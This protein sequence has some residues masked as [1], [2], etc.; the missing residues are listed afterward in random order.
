LFTPPPGVTV[1]FDSRWPDGSDDLPLNEPPLARAPGA[2]ATSPDQV[3]LTLVANGSLV[4]RWATGPGEVG[5][6]AASP[7][8]RPPP[9]TVE[10][11]AAADALTTT[12]TS[13]SPATRYV[14]RYPGGTYTS[15][16]LHAVRLPASALVS[17]SPFFYRVG[18]DEGGWSPVTQSMAPPT[19]GPSYPLTLALVGDTGGTHNTSSTLAHV[20]SSRPDALVH[21]GDYTYAD[22]YAPDGGKAGAGA[23]PTTF[24]P[25]WDGWGRL[26][27]PL[28][29]TLPLAGVPGNHEQERDAA[30]A[31]WQAYTHRWAPRDPAG[32]SATPSDSPL[33]YSTT[34][35]PVHLVMIN[36]YAPAGT[37]SA[38]RAWLEK[39]L[40][41][42]DRFLTPWLVAAFHAPWY[43]TS[44]AHYR[45]VECTRAALEPVLSAAGVDAVFAGHVH[46]YE[47]THRVLA[48]APSLCG[49]PHVC[50]GD[51]G[52]AERLYKRYVDGAG[53]GRGGGGDAPFCGALARRDGDSCAAS[54]PGPYCS[55][56]QAPWS[57]F[58]EPS[59]GHGVLTVESPTRA[60]WTWH[61]NQDGV[62]VAADSVVFNRGGGE[63][64]GTR[65]APA[66]AA[67]PAPPRR[68]GSAQG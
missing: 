7:R 27:S 34:I 50:I 2:S 40:A 10:L 1:P 52:N 16:W 56:T 3:A 51:G 22:L 41:A 14:Q 55:H 26:T 68:A 19:P 49:P 11:G 58:R 28:L 30:G 4:V 9:S 44:V 60:A 37:G 65:P 29:A 46:A 8:A 57:A 5:A 48:H 59:Y 53:G 63:C 33:Y 15:P 67:A 62:K 12:A 20:A 35:G 54:A 39:D 6:A 45:E 23:G 43:T 38:Q 18:S 17:G 61:R 36:S 25:R 32:D 47:R 66:A 31:E 13:A 24:Q 21:V 42:V 64:A